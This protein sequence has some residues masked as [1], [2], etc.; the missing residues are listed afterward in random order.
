MLIDF[1]AINFKSFGD[2]LNFSMIKSPIL[3]E[4]GYSIFKK[5]VDSK[6]LQIL[7]TSVIYGPNAYVKTNIV[8]AM[9]VLKKIILRGNIND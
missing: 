2:G 1:K 7:P 3:T 4:L 8:S 5:T 9:E 6:K